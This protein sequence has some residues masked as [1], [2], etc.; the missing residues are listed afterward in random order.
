M[1]VWAGLVVVPWELYDPAPQVEQ[2][3][4]LAWSEAVVVSM[5]AFPLAHRAQVPTL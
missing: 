3:S 4:M 5:M 1:T 2:L